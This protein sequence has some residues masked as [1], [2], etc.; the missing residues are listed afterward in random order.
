MS[1][2]ELFRK[3]QLFD[4]T[5][6]V[7]VHTA[8]LRRTSIAIASFDKTIKFVSSDAQFSVISMDEI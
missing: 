3:R 4:V 7:L 8:G 1:L 5:A 6:I 2:Y